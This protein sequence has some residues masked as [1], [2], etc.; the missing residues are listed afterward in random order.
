[1]KSLKAAV[2]REYSLEIPEEYSAVGDSQS[3][4]LI[5]V[6][7]QNVEGQIRATRCQLEDRLGVDSPVESP[8]LPWLVRH[9]GAILSR[10]ARGPDGLTPYR[11]LRGRNYDKL[12]IESGECVWYMLSKDKGRGKLAPR[13]ETGVY[14]GSSEISNEILVGTPEGVIKVRSFRRQGRTEDRWD[15]ERVLGVKGLPWEVI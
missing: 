9:S 5:E 2:R 6:T 3:N 15:K 10:Y 14:L 11:R 13:W 1:M 12:V 4:G 8:V 7:I